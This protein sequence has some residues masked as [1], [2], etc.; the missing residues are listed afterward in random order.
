MARRKIPCEYCSDSIFSDEY[1]EHRNGY[2]LW[3]EWYP[4]NGGRLSVIAQANDENGE[5]IE[6]SIDFEF[7]YCPFCGRRLD[8]E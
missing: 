3:W 7:K 5:M 2:C 6:D 8:D 4:L 1:K